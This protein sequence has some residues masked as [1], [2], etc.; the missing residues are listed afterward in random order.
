[1]RSPRRWVEELYLLGHEQGAE[2]RGESFDEIF[3][4][5][6]AG[7]MRATVGVI[8]ELPEMY[9]LSGPT[10]ASFSTSPDFGS[11]SPP[12]AILALSYPIGQP[13]LTNRAPA[14]TPIP[15]ESH[16][17]DLFE[18]IRTPR[19]MRRLKPDPVPNELIRKI[20]DAGVCAPAGEI[21]SAGG[22][23]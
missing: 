18:I 10:S 9:K 15:N 6:Y 3:V 20:L 14:R 21:C 1:M 8:I 5:V 16:G 13:R 7:P 2:L 23:L 17:P 12:Q 4:R 11:S 19:S 22:F